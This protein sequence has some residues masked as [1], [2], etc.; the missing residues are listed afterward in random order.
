VQRGHVG[1]KFVDL[2]RPGVLAQENSSA[3]FVPASNTKLYTAAAA[4][5]RLGPGY[6]FRTELRTSSNFS[7]GQASLPDLQLVGGGDPNLSGRVLPYSADS[8]TGDPLPALR[9]LAKKLADSG[10]KTIDGDVTGIATRYPGEMYP[11][12]WTID[13]S[14]YEYGAPVSALTFNDNAASV[15]VQPGEPGELAQLDTNPSDTPLIFL[16]Q[17][18]TDDS[19]EAHVHL[20]RALGSNEVVLWG[21]IGKSAQPWEQDV[22][23]IDPA[24]WAANTLIRVLR[25]QGITVRGHAVSRYGTTSEL[26][27]GLR[28]QAAGTVLAVHQSVP[29][30][31][32]LVVLHKV[33]QNL[34]AEMLLHELGFVIQGV[35]SLKAGVEERDKFLQEIGISERG[36]GI[37]LTDGS[38]L[39]RQDLTTPEST[40]TLLRAMWNRPERDVWL[41]S[42]PIGGV[43]GTLE[44][45]F[46]KVRG[47]ERIHAKT[48]S[49]AHVNSLSG[50]METK[51]GHWIAFSV[52]VN[53]TAGHE[54]DVRKFIDRLCGLFLSI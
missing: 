11:D 17:V 32:E 46:E 9:E 41:A 50:Y 7:P 6:L 49:L 18:L 24:W 38:G 30:A 16:N 27:N 3:F 48:G 37:A 47:A 33:S 44:H 12:G 20:E 35:G 54:D 51:Q 52:M 23:V 8:Q 2:T 1:F 53:N 31:E 34:H 25:E 29:L 43:D 10:I 5:A 4:L 26:C 39:A 19:H 28:T 21:S 22:A 40:V 14:L 42:L 45:R 15:I 36:T 13:D